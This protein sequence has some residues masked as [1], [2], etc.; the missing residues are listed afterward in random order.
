[1]R[2]TLAG[3]IIGLGITLAWVANSHVEVPQVVVAPPPPPLS[4]FTTKA[5]EAAKPDLSPAR[6]K[7]ITSLLTNIAAE[8][9]ATRAQQE[10]WISL[11]GLESRFDGRGKSH[12]G[13]VGLGQLMPQYKD[14]FGKTCGLSPV[15][16]EDIADDYTNAYLSACFFNSL[17]DRYGGNIPLALSAYNAGSYSV[18][19]ANI[20]TGGKIAPETESYIRKIWVNKET[21]NKP[22]KETK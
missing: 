15:T 3:A 9:F 20:K 14:D 19:A 22:T 5:I 10:F 21:I 4:D 1:M 12:K 18:S 7:L 13:A 11:I 2:Y 8:T 17:L 16:N 6:I